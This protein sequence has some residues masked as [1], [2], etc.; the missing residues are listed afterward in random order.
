MIIVLVVMVVVGNNINIYTNINFIIFV[1]ILTI[2]CIVNNLNFIGTN[3]T[4]NHDID[5]INNYK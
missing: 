5:L 3:K 2:N 4:V 1:L